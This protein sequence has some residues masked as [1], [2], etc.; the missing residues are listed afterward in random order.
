MHTE[1]IPLVVAGT[2]VRS[3][4]TLLDLVLTNN[5]NGHLRPLAAADCIL[6]TGEAVTGRFETTGHRNLQAI[7][8]A[9]CVGC[10]L[11]CAIRNREIPLAP[12]EP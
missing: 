4:G 11:D 3:D 1:N 12:V 9:S 10:M 5:S 2:Q 7:N 8:S 6:K